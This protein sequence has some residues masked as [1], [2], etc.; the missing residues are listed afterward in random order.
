M[1]STRRR[2]GRH[3]GLI[4]IA[5]A[6]VA[7]A[8]AG[9][10]PSADATQEVRTIAGSGGIGFLDGPA[11][12]A[13]FST[14]SDI[15][16]TNDGTIYISDEASQRVRAL[17]PGGLVKT[18]AG[19]GKAGDL[20]F[21]VPGGYRDG[22]AAQALFNHPLGM[23]VGPDGALYI[24]DS[25]NACIRKLQ[26]GA[27]TTVVGTPGS[28]VSVDGPLSQAR[29]VHWHSTAAGAFGLGTSASAFADS[30]L[31]GR[32]RRSR[33]VREAM[34]SSPFQSRPTETI[35]HFSRSRRNS[36]SHTTSRPESAERSTSQQRP[37]DRS[38]PSAIRFAS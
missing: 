28:T 19:S 36:S 3:L 37:K 22:P 6:L 21:S 35:Q 8:G 27:V 4:G 32:S 5:Y 11:A 18:V 25:K 23:A 31:T 1:Q 15:V 2:L 10:A 12:E 24:A 38:A 13:T 9:A 20:G 16:R 17:T 29:L 34:K 7:F 14:P 33:S 30:I 26:N